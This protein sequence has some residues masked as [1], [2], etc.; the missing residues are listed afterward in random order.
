[1]SAYVYIK[2]RR[3]E[4]LKGRQPKGRGGEMKER[5]GG[6]MGE[7]GS[8]KLHLTGL[9]IY[10]NSK[11]LVYYMQSHILFFFAKP[12]SYN[13]HYKNKIESKYR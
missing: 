12:Y 4:I 7:E 3:E 5:R 10:F 6:R 11:A 8:R 2:E 1:M 9:Q 13:S